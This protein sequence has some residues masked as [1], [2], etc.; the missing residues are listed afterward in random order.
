M[1]VNLDPDWLDKEAWAAF[2][3]MRLSMGKKVPFT[4]MAATRIIHELGK[5]E[6]LGHPNGEVL[7]QSVM[8]GYRGVFPIK[9]QAARRVESKTF[10]ERDADA[11]AE[12]V[13]EMTGGII[14]P[15][16]QGE[17]FEMEVPSG[18]KRINTTH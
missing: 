5:L 2:R 8:L 14:S 9:A 18:L 3:E 10:K 12:R 16:R 11:L 1:G 6:A 7:W 4:E 13:R 17:V 15:S